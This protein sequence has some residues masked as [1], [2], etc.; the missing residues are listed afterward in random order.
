LQLHHERE[1]D[2]EQYGQI[3]KELESR[4]QT[5]GNMDM[6]IAAHARSL[7][8]ILVT[9]NERHLGR[10]AGLNVENRTK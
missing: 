5:V 1:T 2:A 6:M 9:N 4:G 7:G 8:M 10:I 3:R